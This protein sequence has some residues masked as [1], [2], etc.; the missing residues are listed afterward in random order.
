M[1][2]VNVGQIRTNLRH[3][4]V[5][6]EA[7]MAEP[8]KH[9]PTQNPPRHGHRGF[10]FGTDGLGM[11]KAGLVGTMGQFA[12]Q[13]HRSL[14]REKTSLAMST[15]LQRMA[16]VRTNAFVHFQDQRLKD[17]VGRPVVGHGFASVRKNPRK[18]TDYPIHCYH[19]ELA[20]CRLVVLKTACSSSSI[21]PAP[22]CWAATCRPSAWRLP[23]GPRSS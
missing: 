12:G 16:T 17:G 18:V 10:L 8:T 5:T 3:R 1:D 2:L 19:L 21:L 7:S 15:H 23:V 6:S 13:M 22:T 20:F 11:T 4:P 9:I 14:E